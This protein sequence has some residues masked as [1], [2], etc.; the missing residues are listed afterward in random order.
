M[1][2]SPQKCGTDNDCG[3]AELL[4][5]DLELKVCKCRERYSVLSSAGACLPGIPSLFFFSAILSVPSLCSKLDG[6]YSDKESFCN[7]S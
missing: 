7:G 2:E 3:D 4:T 1:V 5:C 6:K